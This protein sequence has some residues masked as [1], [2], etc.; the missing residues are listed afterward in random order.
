[1]ISPFDQITIP[2]EIK[3]TGFCVKLIEYRKLRGLTQTGLARCL[4]GTS[5]TSITNWEKGTSIPSLK[6]FVKLCRT[7][8][9]TPNEFLGF[10]D[11]G[12]E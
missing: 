3:T 7:L 2:A 6:S 4:E 8:D 11:R 1:M 10:E 5:R 9:I 12:E